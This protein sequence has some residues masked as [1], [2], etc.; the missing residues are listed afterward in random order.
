VELNG[1][2]LAAF[3]ASRVNNFSTTFSGHS[4]TK[5]VGTVTFQITGLIC[6]FHDNL[7]PVGLK[8]GARF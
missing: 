7:L 1:Q 2:A 4:G 5:A 3:G 8:K 6:S